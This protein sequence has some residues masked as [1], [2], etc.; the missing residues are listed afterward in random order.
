MNC[1]K[2]GASGSQSKITKGFHYE[3]GAILT[4]GGHF[5]DED[6]SCRIGVLEKELTAAQARI[7]ELEANQCEAEPFLT[8]RVFD[9]TGD[10]PR[11]Y[12]VPLYRKKNHEPQ[13]QVIAAKMKT[14]SEHVSEQLPFVPHN[15]FEQR[16][17]GIACDKCGTETVGNDIVLTSY[18]AKRQLNCPKC[19][20]VYYIRA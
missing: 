8:Q 17:S 5:I 4:K 16:P 11:Q 6:G 2:C 7:A 14:V 9:N 3:C 15:P 1:P 13:T 12:D 10:I 19:G 18:P 20:E